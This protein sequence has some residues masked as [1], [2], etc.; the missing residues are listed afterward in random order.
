MDDTLESAPSSDLDSDFVRS[1]RLGW[2]PCD[3]CVIA[4]FSG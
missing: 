4:R 1:D 3:G 2:S